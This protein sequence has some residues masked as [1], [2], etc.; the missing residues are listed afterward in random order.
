MLQARSFPTLEELHNP[1]IYGR[2]AIVVNVSERKYPEEILH[3]FKRMGIRCHHYPL[4]ETPGDMGWTNVL[5][6][7]R[8]LEKADN[9]G[10]SAVVH[11]GL[12]NNRSRVVAEAFYFRKMGFHLEDEYKGCL[13]HLV[14]NCQA[15]HLPRLSEAEAR[16]SGNM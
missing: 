7:V 4:V 13:N 9:D 15:G 1:Y 3:E 10:I 11:C 2:V 12:G 14:F 6:A 5:R 8:V 16:L